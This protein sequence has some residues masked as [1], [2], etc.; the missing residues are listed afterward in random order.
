MEAKVENMMVPEERKA[1]DSIA[2]GQGLQN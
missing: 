2:Q 1:W